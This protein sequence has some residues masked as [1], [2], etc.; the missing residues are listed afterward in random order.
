IHEGLKA[1]P[2]TPFLWHAGGSVLMM[3]G[4][5]VD[6]AEHFGKAFSLEPKQFDHSVD[7]AIALNATGR[8]REAHSVL[9]KIE[10]KGSK[11]SHYCSTRAN[12][13]RALADLTNA[14]RWYDRALRIEPDR[15]KAVMGRA[16]VAMERGEAKALQWAERALK[17]DPGNPVLWLAKA[18]ALDH[19]GDH[20]GAIVIM[21][22]IIAQ[23]PGF[24]EAHRWLAQ[25]R[26]TR[27]DADF[28]SH[29]AAAAKQA[30]QDP[31]IPAIWAKTLAGFGRDAE[32]ADV[33]ATARKAGTE[34]AH[35]AMLQAV[36]AGAAGDHERAEAIF[37][38]L[39]D[40]SLDRLTH[41]ARH[42]IR[43]AE[44]DAAENLL[45]Q[46]LARAPS[47]IG[48]WALLDMIWRL[49]DNPRAEWLHGQSDLIQMRDLQCSDR[50]I[51]QTIAELR[52]LHDGAGQPLG[53]S[54][55]GGTQ[56]RGRL[57]ERTE[58]VFADLRRA[59]WRTLDDY[60]KALPPADPAHPLLAHRDAYWQLQGS[61]SVRLT[62]GG[63]HHASHI[64]PNGIVSSA[65]YLVVPDAAQDDAKQEGWLELGSPPVDLA[66]DLAPLTKIQPK[67]GQLALFPST[68]YHGTSPFG[69][70]PGGERM[71]A[72]FDVVLSR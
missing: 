42:R 71:T 69:A 33:A 12:A 61:W 66:L 31:N 56:T 39:D 63:P 3:Q 60:R 28:A 32:A 14:A 24:T 40:T 11:F 41:E 53:Q 64:H 1:F 8:N 25:L 4:R 62:G 55:R 19:A 54:V 44:F 65:L 29:F 13:E 37:A 59:I 23:A 16:D 57:L 26:H 7:Q 22:Q 15:P 49:T 21:E 30:P 27:G 34:E 50:L 48:S 17:L 52:K 2:E 46:A 51:D 68:L 72:V 43:R 6:A 45:N 10:K 58:K 36:Y 38:D 5:H 47:D 67:R 9:K 35:F 70:D 18:Q 20:D